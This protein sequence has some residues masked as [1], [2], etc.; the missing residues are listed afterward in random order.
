MF[1]KQKKP[2]PHQSKR[3]QLF[4]QIRSVDEDAYTIAQGTYDTALIEGGYEFIAWGTVESFYEDGDET[5]IGELRTSLKMS[6]NPIGPRAKPGTIG[7]GRRESE[8]YIEIELAVHRDYVRDVLFELRRDP[9]RRF[10]VDG[11]TIGDREFRATRFFLF[12]P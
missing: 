11:E 6:A 2:T 9:N 8:E 1:A 3:V 12:T 7:G 10:R 4:A 5:P